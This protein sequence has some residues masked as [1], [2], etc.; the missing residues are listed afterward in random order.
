MNIKAK[1]SLGKKMGKWHVQAIHN[2]VQISSE[3]KMFILTNSKNNTSQND[4]KVPLCSSIL[5]KSFLKNEERYAHS[6]DGIAEW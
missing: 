5:Q 6:A 2:K 3:W 4:N 1:C